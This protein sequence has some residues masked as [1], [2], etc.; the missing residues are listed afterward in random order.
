MVHENEL[1]V[2]D[3]QIDKTLD[4]VVEYQ[5]GLNEDKL[6]YSEECLN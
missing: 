6:L 1:L 3:D 4:L 2:V 5:I